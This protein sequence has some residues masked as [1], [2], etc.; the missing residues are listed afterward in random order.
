MYDYLQQEQTSLYS[1]A[2]PI[3]H[4]NSIVYRTGLLKKKKSVICEEKNFY[5]TL[6]RDC[7]F[8]SNPIVNEHD[9]QSANKVAYE[10]EEVW[11]VGAVQTQVVHVQAKRY[12][13]ID[14]EVQYTY[15]EDVLN[16][17]RQP[18]DWKLDNYITN[19]F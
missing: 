8:I 17:F 7:H 16:H 15:T 9:D 13:E 10:D 2:W 12:Y 14:Q 18:D 4:S 3:H 6:Y 5:V 11:H 19:I 1:Q